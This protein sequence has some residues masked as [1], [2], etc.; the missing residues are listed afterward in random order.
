MTIRGKVSTAF[1]LLILLAIVE[2]AFILYVEGHS[3][4]ALAEAERTQAILR[5]H[6]RAGRALAA[7]QSADRGYVIRG[8][9]QDAQEFERQWQEYQNNASRMRALIGDG[10]QRRRAER[11][12]MLVADW[13]ANGA[14]AVIRARNEG[15]DVTAV[16]T[17]EA[18]PRFERAHVEMTAFEQRQLL[19]VAEATATA[20]Q[21]LQQSRVLLIVGPA[22]TVFVALLML[23][24]ARRSVLAPLTALAGSARR[25][26]A[27]DYEAELPPARRDEIGSLISA[28]AE[29]RAAVAQ[30]TAAL[31]AVHLEL[32]KVINAV[33]VPLLIF[34]RNRTIQVQNRAAEHLFGKLPVLLNERGAALDALQMRN[35]AGALIPTADLP[36]VR[37]LRGEEV[38]AEEIRTRRPDGRNA[39]LLASATP[40]RNAE[41]EISGVAAV[42]QDISRLRE[43]DRMKD[44]FVSVVSH[45]LRTP[46]TAIRGSLQLL[47][48]SDS[49]VPDPD[50]R[51]L[52]SVALR[53]CD[54]LVRII[55]D[56]LDVS[57]IEAGKLL[58]ARRR[59]SVT[60]IVRQSI[61]TIQPLARDAGVELR[62][63]VPPDI[64]TVD[65][66]A[67]RLTQA[68]VN[69]LSNAVKFAPRGSAVVI[70][71]REETHAIV[72]SVA[73]S[74]P[75][76]HPDDLSRLF[77]KFQQLDS[78]G[79]RR[80][81]GT[82]LGLAITK[83]IVEEHGGSVWVE[84]VVG[85]GT[86]F[87]VRL[88]KAVSNE[89][90]AVAG[91]PATAAEADSAPRADV[92]TVL[93]VDD[94]AETR[95]VI[96]RT[97]EAAGLTAVEA[98]TGREALAIV[99]QRPP[100][101][102]TL[103]LLMP[104]GDGWWVVERLQEDPRTASIPLVIV[105]GTDGATPDVA[106]PV[107]RK[108]FDRTQLIASLRSRL[109]SRRQ[110]T[111]L[112]AD[113]DADV[114]HVVRETL[115]RQGCR[116]VEAADGRE[117]LDLIRRGRFDL[118]VL[119]LHMPHVHG[120]DIIRELRD[121]SLS[122]RV[123]IIVLSGSSGEQHSLQS[124]VLGAS[125]FMAKPADALALA[126]EAQRLL[127]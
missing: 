36:P 39:T 65:A 47:L 77:Q 50:D 55:N 53:S 48:A 13:R 46:L 59:L 81:G 126:R 33:P 21:R 6:E 96:R 11:L 117:A 112:V 44:E 8:T 91:T 87:F 40:L 82:G 101:V 60:D 118:V 3:E 114:R 98:A 123:P 45:E 16:L 109:D 10:E 75:G 116:V 110:P 26:A 20:R 30:R 76:I 95:L 22:V 94:D 38:L 54:R 4:N 1:G 43:L 12:A 67:D 120:H 92:Q 7:M 102:I 107:V 73:D 122:D 111:V 85:E 97:I 99:Q 121:P 103:D 115:E 14:E 2:S 15:R 18:I 63:E 74:G 66:D 72:I 58:L 79:T 23:M 27:G 35:A 69:L 49:S 90:P 42:F 86:T 31:T 84:S 71:A 68:A 5:Y 17:N 24:A 106:G 127:K 57:K 51:E 93:I 113:D 9:P 100:D 83:G 52:L 80:A 61:S 28:F 37:A 64:A 119:D 41:R 104:D 88:P 62:S 105:T 29:M 124:L 78:S 19:L 89:R 125:V 70:A 25:L 56:M 32:L 108:P 34:N